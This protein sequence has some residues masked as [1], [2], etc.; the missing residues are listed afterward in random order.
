MAGNTHVPDKLHGYTLQVRHMMCELISL[1]LEKI[2]SVEALE[3]VAVESENSVVAEQIKSVQSDN[4]P[5]ANRSEVFWKSLYNWYQYIKNGDLSLKNTTFQLVVISNRNLTAGIIAESFHMA[6]TGDE[7]KV[8]LKIAQDTLWGTKNELKAQ[9][10]SG[11]SSYLDILFNSENTA[12][13]TQIVKAMQIEI[14]QSN[15]DEN[16]YKKF[17]SLPIPPEY[18]EELF[19]YMLGWVHERVNAQTKHGLA[20]YIQCKDFRDALQSQIR[21]YNQ[22]GILASVATRPSENETQKELDRQDI[23]IKQLGLIK[24][25]VSEKLKAANDFLRTSAEKTAWAERG[26]VALQSFDD[27]HDGLIRVWST[28]SLLVSLTPSPTNI[29]SGQKLYL[30]CQDTVRTTKVQGHDTPEFFGAGSLH[31]LANE[32]HQEPLIGWHPTYKDLLK[33]SGETNE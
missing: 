2:V 26:I 29:Q 9:V 22:N 5:I 30:I 1:D 10:S 21:R 16:F 24:L 3:D 17:C 33:S 23:Y 7:A 4:N 11:Y 27:Y 12:I 32:P 31:S 25:D 15:Y 13:V 20:A 6:H 18:A 19:T 28:Q 8:A 14:H